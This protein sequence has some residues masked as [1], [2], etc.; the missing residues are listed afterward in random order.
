MLPAYSPIE[1]EFESPQQASAY[2]AWLRAKVTHALAQADDPNSPRYSTDEVRR[3]V[4]AL[5]ESR[6]AKHPAVK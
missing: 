6:S 1:S 3:R 4:Y 5:I 2:G